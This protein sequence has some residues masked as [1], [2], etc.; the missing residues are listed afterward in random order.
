MIHCYATAIVL[1]LAVGTV[2][3]TC[4]KAKISMP[5]R[6]WIASRRGKGWTWLYDLTNCPYCF[7]HWLAF[8]AV[9]VWQQYVIVR[10]WDVSVVGVLAQF[11]V[12]AFAIVAVSSLVTLVIK[13]ATN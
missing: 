12:T 5:P 11:F 9:A 3:W 8:A 13:K 1:A 7:S 4:T 2:A 6:E 10:P